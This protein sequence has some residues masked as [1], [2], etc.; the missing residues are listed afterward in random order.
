[1]LGLFRRNKW[2]ERNFFENK[3]IHLALSEIKISKLSDQTKGKQRYSS[4]FFWKLNELKNYQ[5][6]LA[7]LQIKKGEQLCTVQ[8]LQRI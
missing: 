1:M 7:S 5:S 4:F 6:E 3:K 2:N 8:K